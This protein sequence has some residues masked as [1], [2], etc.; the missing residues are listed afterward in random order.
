VSL[1]V[2]VLAGGLATRLGPVAK[3]IPKSLVEV[4]GRP[5]AEHQIEWLQ[6]QGIRRIVFLVAHLGEMVAAALGDGRRWGI[7]LEYVYDGASLLGTGGALRRALPALGEA[8]F[9]LYGDSL[10]TCDLPSI[11]RTFRASGCA[12]LMTVLRN[13]DRWDRSNVQF[14]DGRIVR[15][16][17]ATRTPDMHHVDYGIG[18]LTAESLSSF[19]DDRP[20][21]LA[22]VYQRL[23]A[24]GNLA[25]VELF[26]R[27]YEIGSREGLEATRAFLERRDRHARESS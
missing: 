23:V 8:F 16:D 2:A 12:G 10:L 15:Y 14:E 26:E 18:V 19:P 6:S 1:P 3:D 24:A 5:F 27:F 20:F 17:K 9:V 21:D 11:E 22:P 13:D 4:A 7:S 25:A